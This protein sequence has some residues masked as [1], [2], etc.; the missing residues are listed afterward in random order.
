MCTGAQHSATGE[1]STRDVQPTSPAGL[2]RGTE[3]TATDIYPAQ[4]ESNAATVCPE[5]GSSETQNEMD[6]IMGDA[7]Q[8]E[9]A[10][11]NLEIG[12]PEAA[13]TSKDNTMP[14]GEAETKEGSLA[15]DANQES[16]VDGQGTKLREVSENNIPADREEPE[17]ME[18]HLSKD[19]EQGNSING[20]AQSPKG[21]MSEC[22]TSTDQAKS[23]KGE[24]QEKDVDRSSGAVPENESVRTPT[25]LTTDNQDKDTSG[26]GTVVETTNQRKPD[27]KGDARKTNLSSSKKH[28]GTKGAL[29]VWFL[30]C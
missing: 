4:P 24:H 12:S 29:Q 10:L 27:K 22:N 7:K 13:V 15:K 23:D 11:K 9:E 21:V 19:V 3:S 28:S 30:K 8:A 2:Q 5:S 26:H 18:L 14:K 17:K 1:D 6:E 25:N 20:D 16:S